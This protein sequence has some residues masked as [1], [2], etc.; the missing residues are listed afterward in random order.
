MA[1]FNLGAK[2][3]SD[4]N[5]GSD[6][7]VEKAQ[8]AYTVWNARI[9]FGARSN[10]SMVELWGLNLTDEHYAQV[11]FDAPLQNVSPVPNNPFNSFNAFLGAPRTYGMTL[12]VSY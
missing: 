5:T 12:R 2:Y 7:D 3:M 4:Y 6:K 11:G 10:R 8:D 1:R 9:G